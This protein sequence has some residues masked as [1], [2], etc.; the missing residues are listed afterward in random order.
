MADAVLPLARSQ[1]H[2]L[3]PDGTRAVLLL[4]LGKEEQ[5]RPGP[6]R[7]HHGAPKD[8]AGRG[9]HAG[10]VPLPRDEPHDR[11]VDPPAPEMV[12][13]RP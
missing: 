4:L 7:V 2:D 1:A 8:H 12:E 9:F 11:E 10:D 5:V 6:G 3:P 13:G